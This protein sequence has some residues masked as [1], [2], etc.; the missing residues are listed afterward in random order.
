MKNNSENIPFEYLKIRIKLST[1]RLN[2][3]LEIGVPAPIVLNEI[4]LLAERLNSLIEHY[5][6]QNQ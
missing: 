1:D 6:N 2:R 5:R 3:F 4:N